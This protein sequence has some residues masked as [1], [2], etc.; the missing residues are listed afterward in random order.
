MTI[1]QVI[2]YL[3]IA[4]VVGMIA[5]RLVGTGPYGLIGNIIVGL[6]GIWV[7][8]NL[9]HWHFTPDL[10]IEGVPLVTAILG[11]ILVDLV[12]SLVFRGTRGRR[13]W[14]RL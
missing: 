6:V 11:A 7:M 5:E 9:L 3:L 8:L 4:A 2:V 12:L 1:A 10:T 14:R 13:S